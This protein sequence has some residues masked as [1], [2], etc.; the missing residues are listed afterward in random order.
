MSSSDYFGRRR[1]DRQPPT[2]VVPLP[3]ACPACRSQSIST[4]AR[5]PTE[6]CYWR[7]DACGEIWNVSRRAP[8]RTG[9]RR[10]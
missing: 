9:Y 8:V 1:A 7:C 4:T 3:T 10:W 5:N 2:E 6:S